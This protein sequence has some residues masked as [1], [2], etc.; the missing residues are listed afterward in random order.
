MI[1]MLFRTANYHAEVCELL[2]GYIYQSEIEAS[3]S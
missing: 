2:E 1:L 3:Y